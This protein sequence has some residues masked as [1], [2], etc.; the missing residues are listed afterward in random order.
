ML[1]ELLPRNRAAFI[2][3]SKEWARDHGF[4]KIICPE[5]TKRLPSFQTAPIEPWLIVLPGRQSV[6]SVYH[7]G[8][9][10]IRNDLAAVLR[11]HMPHF[12]WGRCF[13][14]AGK[15]IETH[16]TCFT[17]EYL[18][19]RGNKESNYRGRCKLCGQ[20]QYAHAG[21]PMVLRQDLLPRV[22]VYNGP[23]KELLVAKELADKIDWSPFK[24][25]ELFRVVEVDQPMDGLPARVAEWP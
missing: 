4:G 13:T 25:I 19:I 6:N 1:Y 16:Q 17:R 2:T 8:C 12:T 7:G 10:A 9:I 15:L 21:H 5:C 11:A 22:Q 18:W 23:R 14:A 3:A 24:D 20:P